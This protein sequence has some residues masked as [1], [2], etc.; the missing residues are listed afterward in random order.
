M[1]GAILGGN[2]PLP[3]IS[4]MEPPTPTSLLWF[5]VSVFGESPWLQTRWLLVLLSVPGAVYLLR[6]YVSKNIAVSHILYFFLGI[7]LPIV[8]YVLSVWGP[9]PLFASRQMLGAAIAFV[10]IIGLCIASLPRIFAAGFFLIF[11]LWT[12]GSMPQSFPQN[13]KPPWTDIA[14][15][16]DAKYNSKTAVALENWIGNPLSYYRKIGS[17][18]LWSELSEHEQ[19]EEL[20]FVCRPFR[21]S[22]VETEPIKSRSSLL[23][24]W[25]WGGGG[26]L[27]EDRKI[28]M[29]KIKSEH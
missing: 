28:L 13:T 23:A 29:Y 24:T 8:V 16:I 1:G 15:Q 19:D 2:D 7:G 27:N 5:Y 6:L 26:S 25:R 12:A 14:A 21:C 11:L 10:A 17:V 20:L 9:K 4:W 18:R 3:H 22:V